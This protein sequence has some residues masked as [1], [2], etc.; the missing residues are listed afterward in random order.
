MFANFLMV[1]EPEEYYTAA[2]GAGQENNYVLQN[3]GGLR[4]HDI[5]K[6]K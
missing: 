6:V 3:M 2:K 4:K 5:Q 1:L